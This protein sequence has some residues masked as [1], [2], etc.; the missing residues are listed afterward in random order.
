MRF[1]DIIAKEY[2]NNIYFIVHDALSRPHGSR[3]SLRGRGMITTGISGG[4]R[5]G[6]LTS[7]HAE[8]LAAVEDYGE[9]KREDERAKGMERFGTI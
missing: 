1:F 5:I 3:G 8:L 4:P 2:N 7:N 9:E 6:G